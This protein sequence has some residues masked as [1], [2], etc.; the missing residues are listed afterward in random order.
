MYNVRVVSTQF[1][2]DLP[3]EKEEGP[4]SLTSLRGVATCGYCRPLATEGALA[5]EGGKRPGAPFHRR[6]LPNLRPLEELVF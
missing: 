3:E 4:G 6:G 5:K 1:C 2:A